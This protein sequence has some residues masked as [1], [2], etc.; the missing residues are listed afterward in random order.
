MSHLPDQPYEVPEREVAHDHDDDYPEG[1]EYI[2]G[3]GHITK[4]TYWMTKTQEDKDFKDARRREKA[5]EQ[6]GG[7][8]FR[9]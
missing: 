6:L 3:M 5:R 8:G 9:A 4:G 7:F 1:S 2:I